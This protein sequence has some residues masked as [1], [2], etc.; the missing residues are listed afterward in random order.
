MQ[1]KSEV[2]LDKIDAIHRGYRVLEHYLS[3]TKYLASDNL[4]LADLCVVAWM[5]SITQVVEVSAY[6]KI[7]AWLQVLQ[8]LQY[9]EEANKNGADLHIKLFRDALK[10]N[11]NL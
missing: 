1:G 4:T 2:P 6:P 11:K 8:K 3:G 7:T 9:Y 5:A 10:Q